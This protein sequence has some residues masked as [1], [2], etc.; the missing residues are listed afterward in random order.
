MELAKEQ[1]NK[2][3]RRTASS[4]PPPWGAFLDGIDL[5]DIP[6]KRVKSLAKRARVKAGGGR[7]ACVER[8]KKFVTLAHAPEWWSKEQQ[9]AALV[10][11]LAD[12]VVS[13]SS[14]KEEE[15]VEEEDF[16][17]TMTLIIGQ[18]LRLQGTW[19]RYVRGRQD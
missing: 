16:P 2:K 15:E 7:E 12:A 11:T 6:F 3:R 5:D 4:S 18:R 17:R 13:E 1:A 8:L 19:E 10:V 9:K 14:R